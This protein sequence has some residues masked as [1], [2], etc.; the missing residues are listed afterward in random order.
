MRVEAVHD[1]GLGYSLNE[2]DGLRSTQKKWQDRITVSI[3]PHFYATHV[4]YETC[5]RLTQR[6]V[7]ALFAIQVCDRKVTSGF[8]NQVTSFISVFV[9]LMHFWLSGF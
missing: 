2:S 3:S 9:F 6:N 8:L 4:K 5:G 1:C 7:I